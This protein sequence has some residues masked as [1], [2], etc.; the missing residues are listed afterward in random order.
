MKCRLLPQSKASGDAIITCTYVSMSQLLGIL[1]LGQLALR[2]VVRIQCQMAIVCMTAQIVH[3]VLFVRVTQLKLSPYHS[4]RL[5]TSWPQ[6][7]LT[8]RCH[9]GIFH[10]EGELS[11]V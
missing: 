8:T 2:I 11:T 1:L 6:A 5:E 4:T 9:F 10:Q 7:P 3:S